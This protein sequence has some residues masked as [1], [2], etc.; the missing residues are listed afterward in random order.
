[1]YKFGHINCDNYIFI[2]KAVI[3]KMLNK[4]KNVLETHLI[5]S[6]SIKYC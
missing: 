4:Y 1:M 5:G 2:N 3:M 6:V